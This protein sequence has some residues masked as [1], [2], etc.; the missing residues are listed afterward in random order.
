MSCGDRVV[1]RAFGQEMTLETGGAAFLAQDS[2]WRLETIYQ[3]FLSASVLP[4][5]GVLLDIGAGFGAFALP[6]AAA[7]RGWEVWC[8]EPDLAAFSALCCNIHRLGLDNLKA[9]NLAVSGTGGRIW[10]R[11]R[12]AR[13]LAARD[14]LALGRGAGRARFARHGEK[15]GYLQA[16]PA[17]GRALHEVSLPVLPADLLPVLKPTFLKLVAPLAEAGILDALTPAPLDHVVG[18]SWVDLSLAQV[19][20]ATPR[21]AHLCLPRAGGGLR[22]YRRREGARSLGAAEPGLDMMIAGSRVHEVAARLTPGA[23]PVLPIRL[24]PMPPG[25]PHEVLSGGLWAN[26]G[27][28]LCSHVAFV[29]ASDDLDAA[30]LP[31]LRWRLELACQSGAETVLACRPVKAAATRSGQLF[32]RP[33]CEAAGG[34]VPV[35]SPSTGGG[36]GVSLSGAIFRRDFL[37]HVSRGGCPSFAKWPTFLARALAAS[38]RVL[39]PAALGG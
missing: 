23:G 1:L 28:A 3:P 11:G 10:R 14:P 20:G 21:V 7:F 12:L 33:W 26:A 2:L 27:R 31:G 17:R 35:D 30:S 37:D 24:H 25:K 36:V 29:G 9:V 6:F 8:F 5:Q 34:G 18:E 19:L 39:W 38:P 16:G 22:L 13:A 32:A 15:P 4:A